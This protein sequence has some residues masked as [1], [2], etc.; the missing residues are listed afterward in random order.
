MRIEWDLEK[1][2]RCPQHGDLAPIA[3]DFL[4]GVVVLLEHYRD[5]H[6]AKV[7]D[8]LRKYT[9]ERDKAR[10]GEDRPPV[11]HEP[12]SIKAF[13]H[14][15]STLHKIIWGETF[16]RENGET[17]SVEWQI[18]P[19]GVVICSEGWEADIEDDCIT[20]F[21]PIEEKNYC[22]SCKKTDRWCYCSGG[23]YRS[24]GFSAIAQTSFDFLRPAFK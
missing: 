13:T 2:P 1:P 17:R 6:N 15:G 21:H 14:V 4:V 12:I 22:S 9:W 20:G 5:E 3:L 19:T 16:Y 11:P 7:H 23:P 8:I 18:F 10:H 24:F